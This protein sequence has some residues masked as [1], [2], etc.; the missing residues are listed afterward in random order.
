MYSF[1]NSIMFACIY[2]LCRYRVCLRIFYLIIKHTYPVFM[3][4]IYPF[5]YNDVQKFTFFFFFFWVNIEIFLN[6]LPRISNF[7]FGTSSLAYVLA[8]VEFIFQTVTT[9]L[10]SQRTFN[11]GFV[12]DVSAAS[13]YSRFG[14]STV[15]HTL[16]ILL[17]V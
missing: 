1:F 8:F 9:P 15:F 17:T 2:T 14:P 7:G 11:R 13:L 10:Q 12:L 6:A 3:Y 4:E 16:S 5:A